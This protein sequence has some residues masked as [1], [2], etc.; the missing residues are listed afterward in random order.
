MIFVPTVPRE[1]KFGIRKKFE[2][3]NT[4]HETKISVANNEVRKQI[5]NSSL[6]SEHQTFQP[7]TYLKNYPNRLLAKE[8]LKRKQEK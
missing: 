3:R 2:N 7:I 4:K 8:L 6:S 1:Q 5:I